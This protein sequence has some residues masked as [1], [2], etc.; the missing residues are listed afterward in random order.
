[1]QAHVYVAEE[2]ARGSV[3]RPDLLLVG[4]R[5]RALLADHY[6]PPPGG[7][8]AGRCGLRII[9]SRDRDR[10]EALEP[11]L[12]EA[13][14][15]VGSEVRDIQPRTVGPR[16]AAGAWARSERQRGI[17][18]RDEADLVVARQRADRALL[19]LA[20]R[21]RVTRHADAVP[22]RDPGVRRLRPGVAA[23]ERKAD[24]R[25]A[26]VGRER[27][28]RVVAG[29]AQLHVDVVVGAGGQHVRVV[30][31][32]CDRGLVLLVAREEAVVAAHGHLAVAA[33]H[34]QGKRRSRQHRADQ[35]AHCG[36]RSRHP[37]RHNPHQSPPSSRGR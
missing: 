9:R 10:L 12:A 14:A 34:G 13:R 21:V 4:E 35:H 30:C 24:P 37:A 32:D 17:A 15:Y 22:G 1:M 6:R 11:W 26:H 20:R 7:L 18:V 23:V 25:A 33:V 27:A 29:V 19:G 16:E 8:V 36:D 31:I 5:C 2:L 3:V 28:G